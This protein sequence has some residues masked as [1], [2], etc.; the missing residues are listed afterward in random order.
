MDTSDTTRTSD[1]TDDNALV[2]VP[3]HPVAAGAGAIAAGVATGAVVGTAA[4]PIGTAVGAV[5]GA[6]VG[7]LGG[8][9]IASSLSQARDGEYW[10][11]TY[12]SR[13]YADAEKSY[14]DYGPAYALGE[15]A[16]GRHAGAN[17]D[18]VD[19]TLAQEWDQ[20]RGASTLGWDHARHAARDAWDRA[21][22]SKR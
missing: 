4:G 1:R 9:A 11:E 6:V 16:R 22:S 5:V 12:K 19:G 15:T 13:P 14:D 7:A 17:F 21:G 8:D 2:G 10:R 3:S 20:A 18:D